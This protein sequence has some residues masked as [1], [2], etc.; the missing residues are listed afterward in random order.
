M[1]PELVIVTGTE[2]GL[3]HPPIE[4]DIKKR[5]VDEVQEPVGLGFFQKLIAANELGKAKIKRVKSDLAAAEIQAEEAQRATV[6]VFRGV[7]QVYRTTMKEQLVELETRIIADYSWRVRK[8]TLNS[9]T[10]IAVE[11]EAYLKNLE[12]LKLREGFFTRLSRMAT[13]VFDQ[14]CDRI[15]ALAKDSI[16]RIG[17][18]KS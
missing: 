8:E 11:L 4:R 3:A 2:N 1:P 14:F 12:T 7:V 18:A 16:K 10:E 6:D 15:E 5:F 9:L 17:H 13:E